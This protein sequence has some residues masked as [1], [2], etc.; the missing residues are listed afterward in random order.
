[1]S[2]ASPTALVSTDW[3]AAHLDD[4]DLRIVDGSFELPGTLP[5]TRDEYAEDH[6]PGAVFFDIEE[7]ADR[8][9]PLPHMLPSDAEMAAHMRRLGLGDRHR[10]VVYDT[11]GVSAAP[12]VWW[13]VRAYGHG[14]VA[15]LDGGL[16]KWLAEGRPVTHV[17]PSVPPAEFTARL[18]RSKVRDK[19][20]L[21]ANLASRREQVVDARSTPRFA[22]TVPEPRPE[23]RPGHIPGARSLPS[24]Q[25]LDPVH[26]T[27]LPAPLLEAQFRGIGLDR[28]Q[29]IVCSC[30]SG[31]TACT[32]AFGLHLIGWPEAAIYDGSWSEWGLPGDTP[33]ETGAG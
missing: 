14:D 24:T 16:T 3:L 20:Q 31:I 33:I 10:I 30:G 13:M 8:T 19:A 26:R 6:I 1:M 28:N 7:I 29:P 9:T 17:V 18:D 2:Y 25:L 21:L 27:W 4:P 11:G 5:L 23:L 12:R 32:L 15:I 22:G